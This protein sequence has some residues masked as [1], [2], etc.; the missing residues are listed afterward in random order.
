MATGK[1]AGAIVSQSGGLIL[2]KEVNS[3]GSDLATP[4]TWHPLGYIDDGTG[5][6]DKTPIEKHT[7]ETGGVVKR[8]LGDREVMLEGT[9]MQ[10]DKDL[11]DFLTDTARDKY[12]ALYR[13]EGKVDGKE[14]E[15]FF[16]I[17][18]F[19]PQMEL[20]SGAKRIPFEATVL[21][22]ENA[23]TILALNLPS[24]AKTS[25]DVTIPAGKFYVI[26]ET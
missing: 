10:S 25:S 26:V 18:Q 17:C 20:K 23:I 3:D 13:Y 19:T 4:D 16:G 22:N 24:E 21:K 5:P 15:F 12:Y 8:S 6:T 9:L 14:Q 1:K 2:Y 11:I 7:D